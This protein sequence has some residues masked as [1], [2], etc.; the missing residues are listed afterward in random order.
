[1]VLREDDVVE[2]VDPELPGEYRVLE[3]S[4][5][6]SSPVQRESALIGTQV[7][8]ER[9]KAEAQ[10]VGVQGSQSTGTQASQTTAQP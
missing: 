6:F 2:E 1:M 7:E 3:S 4:V 5:R 8:I 10:G 9:L